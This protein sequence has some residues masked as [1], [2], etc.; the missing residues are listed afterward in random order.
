LTYAKLGDRTKAREAL[1]W[2][3]TL[4]PKVGGDEGPPRAGLGRSVNRRT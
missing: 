1:E 4:D 3:L 2:A